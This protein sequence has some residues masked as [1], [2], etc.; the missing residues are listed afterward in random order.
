MTNCKPVR[1]SRRTPLHGI[2]K[3]VSNYV[4]YAF[5]FK[6]LTRH[7]FLTTLPSQCTKS[8]PQ[9]TQD[10]CTISDNVTWSPYRVSNSSTLEIQD[11]LKLFP[12]VD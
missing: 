5:C 2:S 4:Y 1:F 10:V 6:G 8:V 7:L 12:E 11:T 9:E 3:L